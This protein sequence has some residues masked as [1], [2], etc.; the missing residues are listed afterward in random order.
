MALVAS[1]EG[2]PRLFWRE[3]IDLLSRG[4]GIGNDLIDHMRRT[5]T[6]Q[7]ETRTQRPRGSASAWPARTTAPSAASTAGAAGAAE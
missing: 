1:R 4:S 5:G 2:Q 7:A 6:R 3:H